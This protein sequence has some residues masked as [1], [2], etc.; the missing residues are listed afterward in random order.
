MRDGFGCSN[1]D[2]SDV[3]IGGS[4]G[5]G[6]KGGVYINSKWAYNIT[7]TYQIP[8]IETNF[9]VNLTGR[10]GYVRPYV[11]R[12]TAPSENGQNTSNFIYTLAENDITKFR[13]PNPIEL[14]L[15]LA[16]DFRVYRGAGVT[17]S[18]DAF[19][20]LDRRTILQRNVTRLSSSSS[21]QITELQSPRVFRLGARFNF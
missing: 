2:G 16:K 3:V 8:V 21:N 20:V 7:G 19:N 1:C 18:V 13:L 12:T 15:R 17:L 6:A 14:D 11:F 9:G 10:Q 5:S 4:T